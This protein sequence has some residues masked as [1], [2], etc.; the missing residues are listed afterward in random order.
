M[1]SS[2]LSFFGKILVATVI[3]AV[4]GGGVYVGYLQLIRRDFRVLCE[5]Y[6]NAARHQN[7]NHVDPATRA[8]QTAQEIDQRILTRPV[9]RT[10][11]A[12]AVASPQNRAELLHQA[13]AQS[14]L[15]DWRCPA[16]FPVNAESPTSSPES[17]TNPHLTVPP[18]KP[19]QSWD[20]NPPGAPS[21]SP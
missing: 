21:G 3:V 14:G 4:A 19:G 16:L 18:L 9:R 20:D 15:T 5:I 17:V 13:A 11:E 10:L 8:F 1:A 7:E 2:R 6:E 12:V